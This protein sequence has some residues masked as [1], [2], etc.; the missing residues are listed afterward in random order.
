MRPRLEP[1]IAFKLKAPLPAGVDDPARMLDAIEWVAPSFEIVDCHFADWKFQS[2][3][4]A[5]DFAL[6]WRLIVGTP[7]PIRA[8]RDTELARRSCTTAA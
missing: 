6:H 2:A 5:A 7:A 8:R 4:S 1:E 3:D